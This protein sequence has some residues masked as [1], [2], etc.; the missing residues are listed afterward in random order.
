MNKYI[1]NKQIDLQM[2]ISISM[3]THTYKNIHTNNLTDID[4]YH[5]HK[6][7]SKQ[8]TVQVKFRPDYSSIKLINP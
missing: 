8:N 1:T 6:Q 7:S 3:Y 4:I 2:S 5:T